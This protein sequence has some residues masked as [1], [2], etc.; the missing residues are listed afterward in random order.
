[1]KPGRRAGSIVCLVAAIG[2]FGAMAPPASAPPAPRQA[3]RAPLRAAVEKA[4]NSRD[5]I[6]L[7][8]FSRQLLDSLPDPDGAEAAYPLAALAT[9]EIVSGRPD[10]ATEH[11]NRAFKNLI[12][13]SCKTQTYYFRQANATVAMILVSIP[14]ER[15]P[16]FRDTLVRVLGFLYSF[17][18]PGDAEI[19][20]GVRIAV[21]SGLSLLCQATGQNVAAR[22]YA[23]EALDGA[24][25]VEPR[26]SA[27]TS[28]Y[29]CGCI[30]GLFYIPPRVME[31]SAD[32]EHN[33]Q[34]RAARVRCTHPQRAMAL[35]AALNVALSSGDAVRL[36]KTAFAIEELLDR[37]APTGSLLEYPELADGLQKWLEAAHRDRPGLWPVPKVSPPL[38]LADAEADPAL[39]KGSAYVKKRVNKAGTY[40]YRSWRIHLRTE[41]PKSGADESPVGTWWLYRWRDGALRIVGRAV[42]EAP[43]KRTKDPLDLWVQRL[44]L[45]TF[46]TGNFFQEQNKT[47]AD[48]AAKDLGTVFV[49]RNIIG[50]DFDALPRHRLDMFEKGLPWAGMPQRLALISLQSIYDTHDRDQLYSY[51]TSG[52]EYIWP[53]TFRDGKVASIVPRSGRRSP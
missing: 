21:I 38:A 27:L 32:D 8:K 14:K 20:R 47:E 12:Q 18:L 41:R 13:A 42:C 23:D 30:K 48:T 52:T 33:E 31:Y 4:W 44:A 49:A 25:E 53:V 7:E 6:G 34:V 45:E 11:L 16:L 10:D 36:R 43:P 2:V 50:I 1:M 26:M 29:S 40:T 28:E 15:Q 37:S 51:A 46:W 39:G 3:D 5:F 9:A 24:P 22:A 17:P 35:V 19:T